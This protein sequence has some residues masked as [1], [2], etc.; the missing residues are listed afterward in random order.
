MN[1][2]QARAILGESVEPDGSLFNLG[3]Y[4]AWDKDSD[5]VTLDCRF[6]ADE[7]EAIAWWMRNMDAEYGGGNP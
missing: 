7:L 3:H 6:T 2:E 1:E 4:I 5:E